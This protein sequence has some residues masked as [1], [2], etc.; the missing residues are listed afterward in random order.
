M[1]ENPPAGDFKGDFGTSPLGEAYLAG[2]V[3]SRPIAGMVKLFGYRYFD[4]LTCA[5]ARC[6]QCKFHGEDGFFCILTD[7]QLSAQGG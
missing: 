4:R 3:G 2:R 5:C 1:K 7:E 6:R